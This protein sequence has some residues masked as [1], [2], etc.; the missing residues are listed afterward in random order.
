MS[1]YHQGGCRPN[2]RTMHS[3]D[4]M[5]DSASARPAWLLPVAGI[6]V[7]AALVALEIAAYRLGFRGPTTN[8]GRDFFYGPKRGPIWWAALALGL[9]ALTNRQRLVCL[10]SALVL[11]LA[12]FVSRLGPGVRPTFGN[13]P[14][15]VLVGLGIWA[16]ST[17]PGDQR[18]DALKGVIIGLVLVF[19]SKISDAWL[20]ITAITEPQVLDEYVQVADR[21]LGSPS[22]WVGQAVEASGSFTHLLLQTVYMQLPI[23]AVVVVV[24]QLRHGWPDHHLIRTFLL[25][26]LIGPLCYVIF[27]VVGPAY[28]FGPAGN[29]WAAADIWPAVNDLDLRAHPMLFDALTPRNCMPSLHT[30]WVVAIFIHTRRGPAWLRTFGTFWMVCTLIATLGFGYH[31]GVDLLAGVVFALTIE[32]ALREPERGWGGFRWR[33]VLGGSATLGGLLLSYRYLPT[34][35]AEVPLVSGPVLLGATAAMIVAFWATYFAPEGSQASAWGRPDGSVASD[36]SAVRPANTKA[37]ADAMV[38]GASTAS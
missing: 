20:R 37:G 17:W 24:W 11:D 38:V 29:G 23:A 9:V 2:L 34:T 14:A 25:I 35:M 1:D 32:A 8:Y 7:V 31:Y 36:P 27:P 10:A 5:V 6:L 3:G 13:G 30:A 21:A 28:A 18:R 33:L 12:F 19:T 22:W 26:G 16:A 4:R 15:L